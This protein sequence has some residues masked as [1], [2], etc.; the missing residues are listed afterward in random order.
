MKRSKQNPAPT[1]LTFE[2]QTTPQLMA[3]PGKDEVGWTCGSCGATNSD[4]AHGSCQMCG[5]S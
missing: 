5:G 4:I 1:K 3:Q 2:S